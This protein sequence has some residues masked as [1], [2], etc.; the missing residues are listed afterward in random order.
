MISNR[1]NQK[2]VVGQIVKVGFMRLVVQGCIPTPG[3][4]KPDAYALSSEDGKRF[5]QFVP[6]NGLFRVG[7]LAEALQA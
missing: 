1:S 2:W 5:Y 3:D 6:H 7:N 4:Y